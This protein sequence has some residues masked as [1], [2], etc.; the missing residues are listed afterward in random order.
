MGRLVDINDCI[1]FWDKEKDI[2]IAKSVVQ[3]ITKEYILVIDPEIDTPN[4]KDT[5][6]MQILLDGDKFILTSYFISKTKVDGIKY[7][8]LTKPR[9]YKKIN[10]RN[11]FRLSYI[12]DVNY[13]IIKEDGHK[14]TRGR[15]L[16]ISQSGMLL[17]TNEELERGEKITYQIEIN[18][19]KV[20]LEGYIVRISKY[21]NESF[22]K[23]GLGIHFIYSK[24]VEEKLITWLY[25]LQIRKLR[26]FL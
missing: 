12:K 25:Q 11:H 3:D 9:F 18:K 15:I 14:E 6:Y 16:N 22:F 2:Q 1:I 4:S 24:E 10:N 21:N 26:R 20:T 5:L 8:K 17:Q 23:Y 7:W 19:E 13:T